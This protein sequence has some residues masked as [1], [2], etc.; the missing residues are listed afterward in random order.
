MP[1]FEN[2][3]G[4]ISSRDSETNGNKESGVKASRPAVPVAP[5]RGQTIEYSPRRHGTAG[6][7]SRSQ[8]PV[9]GGAGDK[10]SR[11]R[12]IDSAYTR[13]TLP[14]SLANL[15][16]QKKGPSL[17]ARVKA[18]LTSLYKSLQAAPEREERGRRRR[19]GQRRR[20]SRSPVSANRGQS[21]DREAPR[22]RR[23]RR[24]R[25]PNRRGNLS[26]PK[27]SEGRADSNTPKDL[28]NPSSDGRRQ[29]R[30]RR[31]R[32]KRSGPST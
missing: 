27:I 17:L 25:P 15:P 11:A 4:R 6:S 32:R 14:K 19:H 12:K 13:R 29:V 21:Q 8:P 5:H 23:R 7:R 9:K 22:G 10:G 24:R 20:Q 30:R 28:V 16:P 31:R 2:L 26:G 1:E 18:F 3:E